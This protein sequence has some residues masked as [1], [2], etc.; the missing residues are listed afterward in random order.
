M[1][2]SH[3][4]WIAMVIEDLSSPDNQFRHERERK[5]TF[6]VYRFHGH[7]LGNLPSFVT[8]VLDPLRLLRRSKMQILAGGLTVLCVH[9]SHAVTRAQASLA[10]TDTC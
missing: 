6:V 3:H 1:E 9:R 8:C 2:R 5:E 4:L 7:N 10:E